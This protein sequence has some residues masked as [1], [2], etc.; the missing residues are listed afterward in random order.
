MTPDEVKLAILDFITD[1][2]NLDDV[3]SV[4]HL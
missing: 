1:E 4:E 3:V 2:I